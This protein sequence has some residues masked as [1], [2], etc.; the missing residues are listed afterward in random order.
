MLQWPDKDTDEKLDYALDWTDRLDEDTIVESTWEVAGADTS[1]VT[2]VSPAPSFT[3][4]STAVWFTGGTNKLT[5]TVTNTVTT[6]GG[7]IMQ[8]SAKLR[9]MSK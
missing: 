7:R 8:Q 9:I 1:L 5:Y 6:L 4:T 2:A 3:A